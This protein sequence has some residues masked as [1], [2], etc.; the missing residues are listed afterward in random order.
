MKRVLPR[1]VLG[2]LSLVALSDSA[3]A[4]YNV[5]VQRKSS[6]AEDVGIVAVLPADCP[7]DIDCV[8]LNRFIGQQFS[9]RP[10]VRSVPLEAVR[11]T[12]M[13]ENIAVFDEAGR[14][15]LAE[16]LGVQ[17]FALV[18]IGHA[19]TKDSG[20]VAIPMGNSFYIAEDQVAEGSVQFEIIAANDG[21][22]LLKG[23]GHGKSE[24]RSTIRLLA[25]TFAE[26]F[27]KAFPR[28]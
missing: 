6:F 9:R 22:I 4:G 18:S 12:M 28:K 15:K 11:Q 1:L 3:I 16:K 20:A 26:I 25:K 27:V 24:F 5:D 21:A 14:Q 17:S 7:P 13:D 2:I 19:G 8:W 10:D 23:V